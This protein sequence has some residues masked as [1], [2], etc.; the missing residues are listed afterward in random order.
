MHHATESIVLVFVDIDKWPNIV[1][2]QAPG[3][4]RMSKVALPLMNEVIKR[5]YTPGGTVIRA[6][7]AMLP[8]TD[9]SGVGKGSLFKKRRITFS[10]NRDTLFV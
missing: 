4:P 10:V 6:M 2:S 7:A 3:W 8:A 5:F 9:Y 1:V